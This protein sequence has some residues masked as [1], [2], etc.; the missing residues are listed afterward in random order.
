MEYFVTQNDS[1]IYYHNFKCYSFLQFYDTLAKA[2]SDNLA[3][4]FH[5]WSMVLELISQTMI[6]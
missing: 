1:L 4:S 5:L 2:Q 3:I 6:S